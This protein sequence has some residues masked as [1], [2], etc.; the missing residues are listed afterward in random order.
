MVLYANLPD[1][2]MVTTPEPAMVVDLMENEPIEE[3]AEAT[4]PPVNEEIE[5]AP[6]ESVDV[7]EPTATEIPP[8][9]ESFDE[10]ALESEFDDVQTGIDLLNNPL[11]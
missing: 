4:S 1:S 3:V 8:F 9:L 7:E 6:V 5:V 2:N 11:Q 10:S